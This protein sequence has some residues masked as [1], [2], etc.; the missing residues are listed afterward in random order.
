MNTSDDDMDLGIRM[1]QTGN[2]TRN[3][4]YIGHRNGSRDKN[5]SNACIT[6]IY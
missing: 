3:R 2:G 4:G 1:H 6:A 5:M